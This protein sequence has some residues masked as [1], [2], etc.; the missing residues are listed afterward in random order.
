MLVNGI[1]IPATAFLIRKF[2]TRGLF[3][4]A[5]GLFIVGTLICALAPV[6]PVLLLGR[7]VQA[8]SG[9]LMIPLMQT[10]LFAIY[11]RHERGTAMGTF[12][13]VISFAPAIGPSLSGWVVD[14][15]PWQ[16][17]FYMML[18]IAGGAMAMAFFMLR[19]VTERTNPRLD[20]LS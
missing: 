10:I 9:G 15:L 11:E 13:L 16:T 17:L 12:G 1:M 5:M 3:L 6:Y 8:A 7:V 14:H 19:N 2:T 18:P 20:M 4:T